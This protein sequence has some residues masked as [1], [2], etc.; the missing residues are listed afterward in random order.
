MSAGNSFNFVGRF[1][2]DPEVKQAGNAQVCNFTLASQVYQKKEN[3][4]IFPDFQ[5]WN[6]VA[7]RISKSC[8]KGQQIAVVAQY[9]ENL[10]EDKNGNKRKSVIFR[11]EDFSF[12]GSK[13][14]IHENTSS[15][16][17]NDNNDKD[18]GYVSLPSDIDTNNDIPF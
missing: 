2:A 15:E 18:D 8:K 12:V 11:V 3:V 13:K 4:S 9:T 14:D 5:A 10:W 7:E 6:N 17:N 1:T 16:G